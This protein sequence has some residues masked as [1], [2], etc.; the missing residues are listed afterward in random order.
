MNPLSKRSQTQKV[1]IDVD[2]D[3]LCTQDPDETW[4]PRSLLA[5]LDA[6]RTI[7]WSYI[8]VDYGPESE[9]HALFDELEQR[10]RQSASQLLSAVL[11]VCF[12][13]L[14]HADEGRL[15]LRR[16]SQTRH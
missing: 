9:V 3:Q 12:P 7:R 11:P 5:V 13:Q 10:A 8:F 2:K 6:L 16:G 4:E 15:N 1:I 14:V